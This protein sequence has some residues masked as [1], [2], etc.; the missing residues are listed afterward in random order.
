M[1]G[2]ILGLDRVISCMEDVLVYGRT[3]QEYDDRL[4]AFLEREPV[5]AT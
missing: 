5:Q 2:V 3:K 4:K 1:E